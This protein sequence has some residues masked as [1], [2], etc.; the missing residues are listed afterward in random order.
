MKMKGGGPCT[1]YLEELAPGRF[2]LVSTCSTVSLPL[3]APFSAKRLRL[4]TFKTSAFVRARRW[5]VDTAAS[6]SGRYFCA[7]G[8][9]RWGAWQSRPELPRERQGFGLHAGCMEGAHDA[10]AVSLLKFEAELYR[11]V[12]PIIFYGM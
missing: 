11:R 12:G 4:E 5:V 1:A 9:E 6:M 10:A 7:Q 2:Q 8:C 3:F